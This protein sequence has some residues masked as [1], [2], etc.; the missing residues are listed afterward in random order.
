MLFQNSCEGGSNGTGV[1]TGNSGGASGD[2]FGVV[3]IANG[4]L[5]YDNSNPAHG[6]LCHLYN[7]AA[8]PSGVMRVG[9]TFTA[10]TTGNK[11]AGRI[12]LRRTSNPTG[13]GQALWTCG[14]IGTG[15]CAMVDINTAGQPRIWDSVNTTQ[16]FTNPI[17]LAGWNRIEFEVTLGTSGSTGV[18]LYSGDSLT[19][20]EA[21]TLGVANNRASSDESYFGEQWASDPSGVFRLDDYQIN[22]SGFP[23]PA[24]RARPYIDS[25]IHNV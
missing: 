23:G 1:T 10:I 15:T 17:S 16:T 3:N 20:V 2:A 25:L 21:Q 4:T 12:Y 13:S 18:R 5:N 22:D 14:L 11:I 6:S 9:W 8:S 24:V 19:L 7:V